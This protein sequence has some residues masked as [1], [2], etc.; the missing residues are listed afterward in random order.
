LVVWNLFIVPSVSVPGMISIVFSPAG[1]DV[2]I[3]CGDSA[4]M[5][6]SAVVKR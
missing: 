6:P 4:V 5:R 3:K 1:I 2:I